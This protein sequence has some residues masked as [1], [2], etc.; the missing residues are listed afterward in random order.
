MNL[1][2]IRSVSS[3]DL[4][5]IC[6]LIEK[7]WGSTRVVSRGKVY[8]VDQLPGF[9]AIQEGEQVGLLTYKIE[10]KECE[11]ITIN[12]LRQ[13]IGIGSKLLNKIERY[14][15][16]LGCKRIWLIT[17][18]D[19]LNALHFY[20]KKG[21]FLTALYCNAIEKYRLLKPE[22]PLTGIDGI[23]IRDEL[24]LEKRL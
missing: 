2:K 3:E 6:A 1:I 16:S 9:I 4:N 22:I 19:N 13:N 10:G 8:Y 24:V 17:T 14:A 23:P 18:N 15:T 20:Q 12:S 7:E 21:Y 11:I 5:W